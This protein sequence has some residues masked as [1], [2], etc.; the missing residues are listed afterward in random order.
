[1]KI[2]FDE[3]MDPS[4]LICPACGKDVCGDDEDTE[5]V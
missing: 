2:Y 3:S 4:D 5:E 1:M